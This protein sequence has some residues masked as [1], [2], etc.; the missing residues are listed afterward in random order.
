[1]MTA[2]ILLALIATGGL[3]AMPRLARAKLWRATI[4]PLASIIGSGFLVLGPILD[5]SYGW[6]AP[7]VMAGLCLGAWCFGAAIRFSMAD[8][9]EDGS[10]TG[11]EAVLEA[12]SSWAL[13]FAYVISVAYYLNLFGGFAVSLTPLNG[14]FAAHCVTTAVY[15]LIL[16]VGWRHGFRWLEWMEYGSVTVKLAII[17]AL[18]AGLAV[19][20]GQGAAVG[21]LHVNPPKL[22]GWGAVTLAF[23]LIVTVQGFETARYLGATYSVSTRI[24]AMRRSQIVSAAIYMTYIGLLAYAFPPDTTPLTETAIIGLMGRVAPILPA[25]LVA[26]A[27]SA[28]FSAAVADTGGAGGLVA[29]LTGG[30][31]SVRQGYVVLVALGLGLTWALDIFR[32]I[33]Y[34]SRAFAAYYALQAAI[35]CLRAARGGKPLRALAFGALALLGVAVTV[36]GTSVEG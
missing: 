28:Q 9:V 18:V 27:L 3:L 13:A 34:A 1:M 2:A 32:I 36:L 4:T 31:V 24:R 25:L 16:F 11:T 30:R 6:A 20:V 10:A 15:A 21:A 14:D 7:I 5:D 35:A 29:E 8:G 23:G 26:A 33:S 12:G 17:A 22:S 19:F